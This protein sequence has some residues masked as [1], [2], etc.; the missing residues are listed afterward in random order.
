MVGTVLINSLLRAVP[1]SASVVLVGDTDQLPSV[2]PGNVLRDII[3]SAAVPLVHLQQIFRQGAGSLI[4][5]NAARVNNGE[6]LDLS[7]DY[8]GE[9]D[10]YCI[11]R[12]EPQ[13][14]EQEIISLCAGRLTKKYGFDPIRDVQVLT[15]MRRGLIGCDQL[16]RRLQQIVN[17]RRAVHYKGQ[18]PPFLVGDK[19]MQVR[20]NYDKDVF[21]GDIGIVGAI[22][23]EAQT[24]KVSIDG[25]SVV[26]EAADQ[27]QLVLSYAITIHKSQGSEFPCV[28]IP[29]HTSHYLMLQRN[30]L[31]TGITRGK[32]LVI[33]VGSRKAI[34]MAIRNNRQQ[35]R[36]TYLKERLLER[37]NS[38]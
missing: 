13:E 23:E 4:S 12:E 35:K 34:A 38:A 6:S 8:A 3:D 32:N 19:V 14:I 7:A 37:L 16:N 18:L 2:G 36:N 1:I 9:K 24:L 26:Y 11:F 30:L 21:N 17:S 20:N 31:Y 29:I 10:F 33:L 28:I 25:N 5:L 22:D 27:D 15:P